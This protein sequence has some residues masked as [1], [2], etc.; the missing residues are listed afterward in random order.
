MEEGIKGLEN[1]L[2]LFPNYYLVLEKLGGLYISRQKY[3]GA[4]DIFNRAVAVNE[5]SFNGWYG[6]S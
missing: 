3:D 6:L 5:R 2:K 4:R 1:S